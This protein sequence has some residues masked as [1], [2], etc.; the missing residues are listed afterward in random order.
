MGYRPI[1]PRSFRLKS[2]MNSPPSRH[3]LKTRITL[4]TLGVFLASLWTLS[5]FST[6]GLQRDIEKL[7]SADQLVTA[8]LIAEQL[9]HELKER[10]QSLQAL[11]GALTPQLGESEQLQRFLDQRPDL[12]TI[13]DSRIFIT[14]RAGDTLAT[15]PYNPHHI[16]INFA[17]RDYMAGV[18]Q[19]GQPTIGKPLLGRTAKVPVVVMAVPIL[20]AEGKTAGALAGSMNLEGPTFFEQMAQRHNGR[21]G[22]LTLIDRQNRLIVL[23][24]EPGKAMSALSLDGPQAA[25]SRFLEGEE[26]TT[27]LRD[28][29]EGDRLIAARR[30]PTADWLV[31]AAQ[32]TRKAFAPIRELQR[33]MLLYTLLLTLVAGGLT[34]WLLRRHLAPLAVT[35]QRLDELSRQENAP[36]PLPVDR[37]DEVGQLIV[38]FNRLLETLRR[39]EIALKRSEAHFRL[40]T[41]SASDVVWRLDRDF[42]FTYISPADEKL[43]GIPA[44]SVLGQPFWVLAPEDERPLILHAFATLASHAPGNDAAT[45]FACRQSC[46][47]ETQLWT[48]VKASVEFAAD[49]T[50]AGYHGISRNITERRRMEEQI[51]QLAF[52]DTLTGLP[53]RR[54]LMDRLQQTIA[55]CRRNGSHAALLFI[56]LDNFKPLNDR[57]GHNAGD[58]LLIEVASRLRNGLRELDSVAR[59]GGDEFVVLI[60]ELGSER[61]TSLS[62]VELIA[63]KIRASLAEPYVLTIVHENAPSQRIEHQCTASI[64][65]TLFDET[66]D[67]PDDLLKWADR[68]MYTAKESGRNRLAFANQ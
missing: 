9:D 40:L 5:L 52:H 15:L 41:E 27:I 61:A 23:A 65:I 39:R 3:S 20:D 47:N 44:A 66:R 59:F 62:Q 21:R 29:Q 45:T 25:L 4:A 33:R 37:E 57:Y 28:A 26:G 46:R 36:P 14:D 32:P 68:A 31:L 38:G 6:R 42:L 56:D 30:V 22:T 24:T 51:R 2:D 10:L 12:L 55:A 43:R 11:A 16:G 7:V 17:D 48:E 53:N 13:F 19:R 54:L 35:A 58:L 63:D 1:A 34:W 49:G 50:I 8:G 60:G 67:N 64:G 18:L